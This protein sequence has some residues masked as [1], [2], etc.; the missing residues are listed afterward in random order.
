MPKLEKGSEEARQRM[1]HLR[2]LKKKKTNNGPSENDDK[3]RVE[4]QRATNQCCVCKR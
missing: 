1:A 2:S 4:G 3:H